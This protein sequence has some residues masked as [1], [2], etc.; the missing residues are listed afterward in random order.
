M[1]FCKVC[2]CG[3]KLVY[4]RQSSFPDYCPSCGRRLVDLIAYNEDDPRIEQLMHRGSQEN[5]RKEAEPSSLLEKCIQS[6]GYYLK[7]SNGKEIPI[8]D[9]GGI[10]GRTAL[11]AE[12]LAEYASV[13]RQHMRV[14]IR[15]NIGVWVEDISRYGTLVD[16][17]RILKNELVRVAD[18]SKITLCNVE[19]ILAVR[20]VADQ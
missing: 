8:P 11:G 15:R 7:L 20:E 13:S 6:K 18:G 1:A 10:I 3:E 5:D 14:T 16:G 2:S 4:E 9:G 17:Q 12:V 19:T